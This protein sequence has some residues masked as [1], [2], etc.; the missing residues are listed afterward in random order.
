MSETR[1]KTPETAVDIRSKTFYSVST[2]LEVNG[3]DRRDK[4]GCLAVIAMQF[5]VICFLATVPFVDIWIAYPGVLSN[6][7]RT[8]YVTLTTIVAT[9]IAFTAT[10]QIRK[11]WLEQLQQNPRNLRRTA[12][13]LGIGSWKDSFKFW[14]ITVASI[15]TGLTTTAMIAGIT[16]T[17]GLYETDTWT[18]IHTEVDNCT[19]IRDY[20]DNTFGTWKLANG[21][22]LYV[23]DLTDDYCSTFHITSLEESLVPSVSSIE[24]NHTTKYVNSSIIYTMNNIAVANS[25]LGVPLYGATD[26][27]LGAATA[28]FPPFQVP[29]KIGLQS[30]RFRSAKGCLPVLISNP[31]RCE[32]E[33]NVTLQD[34]GQ[35]ITVAAGGCNATVA[36]FSTNA[37]YADLLSI[38]FCTSDSVNQGQAEIAV[39]GMQD[40]GAAIAL[41]LADFPAYENSTNTTSYSTLCKIDIMAALGFRQVT[42]IL[43]DSTDFSQLNR[44]ILAYGGESCIPDVRRGPAGREN[45][46]ATN[47]LNS[48]LALTVESTMTGPMVSEG[49][50]QEAWLRD[51]IDA[52]HLRAVYS[53]DNSGEKQG[54]F[55]FNNSRNDL[56]DILGLR[57]ALAMGDQLGNGPYRNGSDSAETTV[58]GGIITAKGMRVGTKNPWALA[59]VLPPLFSI[60][61]LS[62]LLWKGTRDSVL[63]GKRRGS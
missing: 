27:P 44:G 49:G 41:L 2:Q 24:V 43:E 3:L 56:E 10:A 38:G 9:L 32:T 13:L 34:N 4:L 53:K 23:N 45:S 29:V 12:T 59:Y 30:S 18:G 1:L 42:F 20:P 52:Q 58:F 36:A 19:F 15:M 48:I 37:D 21:S 35:N 63:A 40:I 33:G 47:I 26:G 50:T 16:P 22:Y 7:L 6:Q 51:I 57:I 61:L 17:T 25:A 60:T 14:R 62:Y 55:A 39:G 8:L 31:V 11:L 54:N 46:N 5:A 28:T